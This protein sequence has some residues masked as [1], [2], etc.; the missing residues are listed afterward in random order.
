MKRIEL[1]V[2]AGNEQVIASEVASVEGR[3]K[4]VSFLE[5]SSWVVWCLDDSTESMVPSEEHDVLTLCYVCIE[6]TAIALFYGTP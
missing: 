1:C 2:Q 5:F 3:S 4:T 6:G